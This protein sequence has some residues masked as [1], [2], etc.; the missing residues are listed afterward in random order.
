M[1]ENVYLIPAAKKEEETAFRMLSGLFDHFMQS[2][3]KL[4]ENFIK[5]LD[6]FDKETVVCDYI[7]SMTDRYA[8]AVFDNIFVPKSFFVKG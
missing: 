8:V 3:E 5:L 1:F 4:P 7:S 6:R 2:P